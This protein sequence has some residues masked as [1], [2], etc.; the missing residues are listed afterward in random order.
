MGFLSIDTI[1][2]KVRNLIF[3]KFKENPFD[4]FFGLLLFT[5]PILPK[6]SN[7]LL[8]F[9][10]LYLIFDRKDYTNIKIELLKKPLFYVLFFLL[11]YW[12]FMGLVTNSL[13]ETNY[14]LLIPVF[15]IPFL[16]LKVKS[17]ETFLWAISAL[18][19][20]ISIRGIYGLL[21]FYIQNHQFLPFEGQVI[22][23][24]LGL[25]RP[26]LG[27][28]SVIGALSSLQL[29]QIYTKYKVWFIIYSIY[30]VG[31]VFLISARI[32]AITV[33]FLLFIFLVFYLKTS[34]KTKFIFTLLSL[35][36]LFSTLFFNKNLRERFFITTNIQNSLVKL[37]RHEPRMVI[38]NCAYDIA[39]DS[40]FN[41]FFGLNSQKVLEDKY[42]DCY[43]Q[44]MENK[45]RAAYF[46]FTKKNSHNQFL[47]IYLFSGLIGF[48]LFT[49]FFIIQ[50]FSHRKNYIKTA[51]IISL[52]LF[53]LVENVLRRQMGTYLF[54]IIVSFINI[55]ALIFNEKSKIDNI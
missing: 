52:V 10:I 24:V 47:D 5:A 3:S 46:I 49:Y 39:C 36:F 2:N 7:V 20:M 28:I 16:F 33:L 29:A 51:M 1:L 32:S 27:F 31:F 40:D 15:I 6:V 50:I 34:V 37:N 8:A 42:L 21:H 9:L 48:I 17:K 43:A 19:F 25:E 44:K 11:F 30:I 12:L 4:V 13:E 55:G 26:Y 14:S 45:Y 18:S 41:V 35:I 22:N 54:I 38:W 53:L 23:E